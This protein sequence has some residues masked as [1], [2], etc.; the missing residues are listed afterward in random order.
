M[1]RLL[2]LALASCA[3]PT[4]LAQAPP[5]PAPTL[6]LLVSGE[7]A[8]VAL[9]APTLA[10]VSVAFVRGDPGAG[11]CPPALR[12]ACLAVTSPVLLGRTIADPTGTAQLRVPVQA[13]AGQALTIQAVM[14]GAR[15]HTSGT[16]TATV[17]DPALDP[18]LD[19]LN[20]LGELAA[21]TDPTRRDTDGGG[22]RDGQEVQVDHTNPLA[23]AD[24]LRRETACAN[25]IDD[26]SDGRTDG[27][28]GRRLRPD[29]RRDLQR[30]PRQ[31]PRPAHRL[32]RSGLPRRAG[33]PRGLH[34]P[35]RQRPQRPEGLRRPRLRGR[36]GL[37]R[38]LPQPRRRRSGL[39]RRLPRP[40]LRAVRRG[41]QQRPR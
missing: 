14:L 9:S 2:F 8:T 3:A 10:G 41:V 35:R 24:D 31:R 17:L 20:N 40:R 25:Q 27:L 18:D 15:P 39:P 28:P 21:G 36:A 26:D 1:R 4:L 11:P 34:R 6:S 38:R 5:P 33:L 13:A 37:R 30:L 22:V 23:S 12:G 19:G 16:T 32:R 7:Q 29:L